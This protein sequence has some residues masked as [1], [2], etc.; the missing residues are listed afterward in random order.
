MTIIQATEVVCDG[1]NCDW[2]RVDGGKG[3]AD[4]M[5]I[6]LGWKIRRLRQISGKQYYC[7]L[8]IEM[9][10]TKTVKSEETSS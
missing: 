7:P 6:Q 1:C 5:A 9:P 10:K 3:A 4:K 8:C 2:F